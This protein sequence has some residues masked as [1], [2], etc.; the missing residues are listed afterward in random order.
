MCSSKRNVVLV[1]PT[2]GMDLFGINVG[3]P[4]SVLYLGTVLDKEGFEVRIVDQRLTTK[5]DE[6]LGSAVDADT[7]MVGISSMT[8]T[9]IRGGLLA[10]RLVRALDR[11]VP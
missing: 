1:Y 8:G 9:Q 7:L 5:F 6:A 11:T 10:A 3:L 2:T 4:L